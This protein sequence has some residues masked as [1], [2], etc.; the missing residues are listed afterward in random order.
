L[1]HL[2][3]AMRPASLDP[4][5]APLTSLKGVGPKLVKP[6]GKLLDRPE[7]RVIDLLFHL[8]Y[9]AI[10]RRGRPKLGEVEPDT[11]V[12]VRVEVERHMPGRGRAPY[13]VVASDET[14]TLEIVYFNFPRERVEKML[15]VGATRFVSGRVGV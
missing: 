11:V 10:D 1:R 2:R 5:F 12:T 8:P 15:P 4:L 9:A 3:A 14:N 13:K 7:P 6:F